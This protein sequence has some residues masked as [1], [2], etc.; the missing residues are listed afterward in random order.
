LCQQPASLLGPLHALL[1]TDARQFELD[2]DRQVVDRANQF[3]VSEETLDVQIGAALP[4]V[5]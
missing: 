4:R 1:V 5:S 2:G 3:V